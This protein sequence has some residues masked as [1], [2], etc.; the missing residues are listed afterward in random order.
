MKENIQVGLCG[1]PFGISLSLKPLIDYWQN[2]KDKGSKSEKI[3]AETILKKIAKAPELLEPIRD[4]KLIEKHRDLVD[5]MMTAI[6]PPAT[7]EDEIGAAI[8]PYDKF[9]PFAT[10][11][12]KEVFG[13][14]WSKSKNKKELTEVEEDMIYRKTLHAYIMIFKEFYGIELPL[15]KTIV[16]NL[17]NPQTGLD[18]H[19]KL[20]INMKFSTINLRSNPKELSDEQIEE[21]VQ[22]SHKLDLWMK[23]LPPEHFEFSGFAI[24]KFNDVT[25][26]EILSQLKYDLLDKESLV[27]KEKFEVLQHKLRS[28]FGIPKLRLGVAGYDAQRAAFISF[29]KASNS[30]TLGQ[31][32][33]NAACSRGLGLYDCMVNKGEACIMNDLNDH[34]EESPFWQNLVTIAGIQNLIMAPLHYEGEFIGMLELGASA[35]GQLSSSYLLQIKDIIPLFSMALKRNSEERASNVDAVIKKQYTAIHPSV[36]W[37][38][39]QAATRYLEQR[40]RKE[41][42]EPEQI[43][44][45]N[46]YPLYAAIDVRGS[47]TERNK[48]IQADL[49]E[50]LTMTKSI[51]EKALT[52]NPLPIFNGIRYKIE[53]HI[54]NIEEGLFS[55]DEMGVIEFLQN[56]IKPCFETL[57]EVMPAQISA[58]LDEYRAKVDPH[59]KVVYNKRKEFEDSL[60]QI[61]E[62]VSEYI[63]NQEEVAQKMFPH[64]FEKYKTDG[65]EYNIYIGQSITNAKKFNNMYLKNIRLWQL[66]NT[67][68]VARKTHA[69]IPELPLPLSTTQLILV[70]SNPLSVRFRLDERQF[71]VD[72]AYNI[73]Y[74]IVKK[75]IDKALIRNTNERLTQPEKVAIVYSQNKDAEEYMEYLEYLQSTGDIIGEIENVELEPLQG[76]QGLRALRVSVNLE[77]S[78]ELPSGINEIQEPITYAKAV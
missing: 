76:V 62:M 73:R 48:A 40:E 46:V 78:A 2:A 69:L 5:M 65:V 3:M 77:K 8:T 41:I 68:E 6:F 58:D 52:Y 55:G 67:I 27:V 24:F 28:L 74:E 50:H 11:K 23:Y 30:L 61:N 42:P 44:F 18:R 66:Q 29:G 20:E 45:S 75:R 21:L 34:V 53:K 36:E 71:D 60:T 54:Q 38:F 49:I 19:Y 37:R 59:L 4:E 35:P 26:P 1:F 16:L 15:D 32:E 63:E 13:E 22:N 43:V 51:I 9:T 31:T 57:E 39:E 64:Y 56:E 47:S 17:P 10:T 33:H 7:T 25:T 72:G 70:H 12:F 14:S